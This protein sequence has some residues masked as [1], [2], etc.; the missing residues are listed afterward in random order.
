MAERPL[1]DHDFES[2]KDHAEFTAGEKNR[3][4]SNEQ[5]T[6]PYQ[7]GHQGELNVAEWPTNKKANTDRFD[8][9]F[10]FTN[11]WQL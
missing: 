4:C 2:K 5:D 3:E 6:S 7:K 10:Y 9:H 11:P 8:A 1:H